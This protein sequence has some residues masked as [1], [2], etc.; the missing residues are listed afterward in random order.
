MRH[1]LAGL[2]GVPLA[3]GHSRPEGL[4]GRQQGCLVMLLSCLGAGGVAQQQSAA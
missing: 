4:V 1:F 3:E 2:Q